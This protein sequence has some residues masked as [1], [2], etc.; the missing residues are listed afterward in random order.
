MAV[1]RSLY[2]R[3]WYKK[4]EATFTGALSIRMQLILLDE[5]VPSPEEFVRTILAP[6]LQKHTGP[7]AEIVRAVDRRARETSSSNEK[8]RG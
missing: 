3:L 5:V 7:L 6:K 8:D 4:F 2:Q 1:R